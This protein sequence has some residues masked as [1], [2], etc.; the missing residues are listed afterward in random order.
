MAV[1]IPAYRLPREL[2]N[3][4]I[5]GILRAGIEVKTGVALGQ[6]FSL[7]SLFAEGYRAVVLAIGA[8]KSIRWAL[9]AR[10][11]RA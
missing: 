11:E 5:E 7:D 2:L 6:D 3:W 4:E 10:T 9:M 8:H 1:G